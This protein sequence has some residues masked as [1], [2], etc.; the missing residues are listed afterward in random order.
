[1]E[2]DIR[3]QLEFTPTGLF[4]W[5]F[6]TNSS[7]RPGLWRS[8]RK[9]PEPILA[10]PGLVQRHTQLIQRAKSGLLGL[11]VADED[12]ARIGFWGGWRVDHRSQWHRRRVLPRTAADGKAQGFFPLIMSANLAGRIGTA[13]V[14]ILSYP[15]LGRG[16][17]AAMLPA[18]WTLPRS[19]HL[20][21]PHSRLT[22]RSL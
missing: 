9:L 19:R 21:P 22:I 3:A 11:Y 5:P 10:D 20:K 7:A 4:R 14:V 2:A 15:I 17:F 16:A 13:P 18:F 8:W 12:G 6:K 1:M